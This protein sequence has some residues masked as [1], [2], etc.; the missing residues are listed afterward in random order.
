MDRLRETCKRISDE[1]LLLLLLPGGP[2]VYVGKKLYDYLAT[3]ESTIDQQ[4][5]AA[6]E[7]IK[8]G[9]ESSISRIKITLDQKAGLDFGAEVE[10]LPVKMMMGKS[11]SMTLEVEYK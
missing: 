7:I 6:V 1:D 4:K 10:G 3:T 2:V 11:G 5:K 9:K 8:Q